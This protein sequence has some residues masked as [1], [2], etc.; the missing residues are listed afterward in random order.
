[1]CS[2]STDPD[3][4]DLLLSEG[5]LPDFARIRR[6]GAY[7]RLESSDPM[8][9]PILW[10]TIATGKSP[11]EHRITHFVA[12]NPKTTP[13]RLGGTPRRSPNSIR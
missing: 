7:G 10:T 13:S 8:L 1:L 4:V 6:E 2:A 3:T 9:S 5:Q 11:A 12:A